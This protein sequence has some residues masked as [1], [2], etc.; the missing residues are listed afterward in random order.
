MS[1]LSAVRHILVEIGVQEDALAPDRALRADLGLDSTETT[2]L[3]LALEKW[4]GVTV[5]LWDR[6]DYT[7]EELDQLVAGKQTSA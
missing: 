3:G 4:H 5:D 7:I 2:E 1:P 6:H